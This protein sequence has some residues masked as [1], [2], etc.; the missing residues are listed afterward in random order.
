MNRTRLFVIAAV[1][2]SVCSVAG[3]R[4]DLEIPKLIEELA[5]D[6][7]FKEGDPEYDAQV[8]KCRE[9]F[10][11][12]MGLGE[13]ALPFLIEHLDDER[14]SIPTRSLIEGADGWRRGMRYRRYPD[15]GSIGN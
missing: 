9:A 10:R 6:A 1:L 8:V 13:A 7:R 5:F 15:N 4:Q 3:A 11:K 12:L 2:A 14:R